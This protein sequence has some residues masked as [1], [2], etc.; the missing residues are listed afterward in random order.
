MT[1]LNI[2]RFMLLNKAK[3]Q[4]V[5]SFYNEE[6]DLLETMN[7]FC[8]YIHKNIRD[9][10]DNQ[11]KYR[12]FTLSDRQKKDSDKR[13]ISGHFDSAYTGEK[14]KVKDS[15]TNRT[16][17]DFTEKDL[18]S[19]DFFYLIH[20]PKNSKF[21]F[22]IVQKKENHGVKSIFENAFNNFM[23][24]KG[25]SNYILEIRQAPP[26]YFIKNYLEFGKLK[27][28][29]LIDNNL[30]LGRE[31]RVFK[32]NKNLS[33][34]Q[35]LKK[36]LIDLFS[37]MSESKDKITFLNKGE[38]D[39]IAFVLGINGSTKTFYVKNH[40]KIRSNVD[41]SNLVEYEEGEPTFESLIKIS[42]EIIRL[43]S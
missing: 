8:G 14:G 1:N 42:L 9:Y 20:V 29:R 16:K 41:V 25:V 2:Y 40:E 15:K 37:T 10:I 5:L 11:G 4:Q 3:E 36:T 39:E 18:I 13:I 23:R 17:Y 7:D 38:Y 28:F 43:A 35:N 31:E 22:L 34:G 12:T 21:G 6:E 32:L 26:R 30:T 33:E 27:E 24:L 19:K